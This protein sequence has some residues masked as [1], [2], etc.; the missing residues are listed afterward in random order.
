MGALGFY[1]LAVGGLGW[2]FNYLGIPE[3]TFWGSILIFVSAIG[4][5]VILLSENVR[6]RIK[7]FIA[8]NFYRSKYDYREQWIKFTKRLGSLLSLE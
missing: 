1:L 3:E 4:L 7:R 5:A 8:M 6:W 2:L